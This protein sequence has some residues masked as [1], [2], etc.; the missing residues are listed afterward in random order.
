MVS[1]RQSRGTLQK[2]GVPIPAKLEGPKAN[3]PKQP[4][5]T[6]RRTRT[7][8]RQSRPRTS[9]N[10]RN[11]S[12]EYDAAAIGAGV[13][14]ASAYSPTKYGKETSSGIGLLE[15]EYFGIIFILVVGLLFG[16]DTYGNKIMSFMKRGFLTSI[17]FFFLALI[18]GVGPNA[19]KITKGVGALVFVA[20]LVS[21]PGQAVVDTLDNFFK[22]D[23]I[24]SSET[25]NQGGS[26][27]ADA[28]T[29]DSGTSNLQKAATAIESAGSSTG[30]LIGTAK[31]TFIELL[32]GII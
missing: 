29:S 32:K 12:R 16:S 17:L 30:S 8:Q 26:A 13:G 10:R 9:Q 3:A 2:Q 21:T 20:I 25:A 23:W 15:A 24:G 6:T 5:Q 4:S 7:P 14:R 27:S 31:S 18:A 1:Q 28:G 19:A 22:Q 11:V